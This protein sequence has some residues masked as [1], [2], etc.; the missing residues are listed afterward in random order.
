M[1][2]E[3]LLHLPIPNKGIPADLVPPSVI[4]AK[5]PAPDRDQDQ[6]RTTRCHPSV[7][8]PRLHQGLCSRYGQWW[9]NSGV[10]LV[11]RSQLCTVSSRHP[12]LGKGSAATLAGPAESPRAVTSPQVSLCP[13]R[14]HLPDS[15]A[16]PQQKLPHQQI[17]RAVSLERGQEEEAESICSGHC[18]EHYSS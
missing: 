3:Q 9:P 8:C 7:L 14:C 6:T 1:G 12:A 11:P 17:A 13:A 15:P 10:L 16:E 2:Q 5:G 4:L 18:P